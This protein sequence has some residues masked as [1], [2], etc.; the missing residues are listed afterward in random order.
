MLTV[1]GRMQGLFFFLQG[2]T[3][4]GATPSA[5]YTVRLCA[6]RPERL[7]A[8][9]PRGDADKHRQSSTGENSSVSSFLAPLCYAGVS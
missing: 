3:H 6:Q 9:D 5:K 1:P 2:E 8:V 4:L 7:R